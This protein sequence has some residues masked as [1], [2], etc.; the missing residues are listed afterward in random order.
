MAE[1]LQGVSPFFSCIIKNFHWSGMIGTKGA[2]ALA[3]GAFLLSAMA[4]SGAV[5]V[6]EVSGKS[7]AAEADIRAG[8][9]L[10]A[11]SR[12][13]Q[14]GTVA[15]PFDLDFIEFEQAP[16]GP[17]V[18]EGTRAGVAMKWT[19]RREVWGIKV[20]P[21]WS[22]KL[23]NRY[24]QIRHVL[25]VEAKRRA[26]ELQNL[27]APGVTDRAWLFF[28]SAE[29]L[30][31]AGERGM[32]DAAY[33]QAAQMLSGQRKA[34]VF[35]SAGT[36]ALRDE[37]YARGNAYFLSCQSV[38]E[39][40]DPKAVMLARCWTGLG[41]VEK[42]RGQFDAAAEHQKKAIGLLNGELAESLIAG[43]VLSSIAS[44]EWQREQF[45][46]AERD[47]NSALELMRKNSADSLAVGDV[48]NNLGLVAES[49]GKTAEAKRY[50]QEAMV[51]LDSVPDGQRSLARTLSNLAMLELDS[52]D[53]E[54]GEQHGLQAL[55]LQEKLTPDSL[56]V[57]YT[58]TSLGAA[59]RD[60][61]ELDRAREYLERALYSGT[62]SLD[63]CFKG[64]HSNES[65]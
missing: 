57:V 62:Q 55:K 27:A 56:S 2:R 1:M 19:L 34:A 22:P 41:Q 38:I 23:L 48:L 15:S 61:W 45:D 54:A 63:P 26:S 16:R 3:L 44:L 35:L 39:P 10:I 46:A 47:M 28:R 36:R 52:G 25:G 7:P 8:D 43:H 51:R 32:A 59:A 5:V 33:Q 40:I 49:T 6:E 12:G 53:L 31:D 21:E 58:L 60:R 42:R 64:R 20:T 18:V 65:G 4:A 13:D 17:V 50:F 30:F 29:I 11:W 37:D 14:A 24:E 9:V